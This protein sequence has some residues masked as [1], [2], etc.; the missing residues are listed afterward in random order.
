[1]SLFIFSYEK[2]IFSG[3]QHLIQCSSTNWK[4]PTYHLPEVSTAPVI[5][6]W[7][8]YFQAGAS[9]CHS[10]VAMTISA[11]NNTSLNCLHSREIKACHHLSSPWLSLPEII[12]LLQKLNMIFPCCQKAL[13]CF[14]EQLIKLPTQ[15]LWE[16]H[17]L[18]DCYTWPFTVNGHELFGCPFTLTCCCIQ[19]YR[20]SHSK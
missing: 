1:M 3:S 2:V 15:F 14:A 7:C 8:H 16:M 5:Q 4:R 17:H 11:P 6:M 12:K 9:G 19:W 18:W 13:G 10:T 20:T